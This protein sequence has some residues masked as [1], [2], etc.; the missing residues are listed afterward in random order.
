MPTL[1]R[2]HAFGRRATD[3]LPKVPCPHCGASTSRVTN[4]RPVLSR[5]GVRRRRQC[6][7]CDQ[8]FTTIELIYEPP[9]LRRRVAIDDDVTTEQRAA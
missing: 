7:G 6:E 9:V 3:N 1:D 8:R 4:S 5:N 2:R